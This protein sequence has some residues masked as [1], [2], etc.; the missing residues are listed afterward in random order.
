MKNP[1]RAIATLVGEFHALY[2]AVQ[3]LAKTHE[4]PNLAVSE[5]ATVEQL[6]LAVLDSCGSFQIFG[7]S[8]IQKG[9]DRASAHVRGQAVFR[10]TEADVPAASSK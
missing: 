3:V 4:N 5:L 7:R 9:A 6:G 8:V 10:R 1:E 2:M